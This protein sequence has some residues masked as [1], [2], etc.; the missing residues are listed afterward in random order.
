L[1]AVAGFVCVFVFSPL[2]LLKAEWK[3]K[4]LD[5]VIAACSIF[6]AYLLTAATILPA[7]EEKA[8]MQKLRS[9]GYYNKYILSYI[10]RAAWASGFLLLLSLAVA[11][12]PESLAEN[13]EF[14]RWFSAVWWAAFSFTVGSVFIATRILLKM[15][16]AR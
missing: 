1:L 6:V 2:W 13:G 9:W 16:R 14:N 5:Q 12:L 15:L 4:L 7:V 11:P 8:I 10:G 3:D